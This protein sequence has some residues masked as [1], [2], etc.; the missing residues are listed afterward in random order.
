LNEKQYKPIAVITSLIFLFHP[1][2]TEVVANIKGR[3]ELLALLFALVSFYFGLLY[4]E[5]LKK[6]YLIWVIISMFLALMSKENAIAFVAIIPVAGWFFYKPQKTALFISTL[7]LILPAILFLIVRGTVLGPTY[8][9]LPDELMNNPFLGATPVQKIATVLYTWVVYFKLLIFPHPLTYDYYPYHIR[10]VD[11]SNS[12]VFSAIACLIALAILFIKGLKSKSVLSFCI[13]GFFA[14]FIL[15]SNLFFPVGTFMN[16]RFVF[17]PSVFWSLALVSVFYLWIDRAKNK[18]PQKVTIILGFYVLIFFPIKTIA[19][20]RVWANDFT[21]FTTDVKTS[22]N[23]AKSNCSAGGKLWEEAKQTPDKNKRDRYYAQ[24]EVYLRKA[25]TIYPQ[26]SDAWLLLGN[27]LFDYKKD[28]EGAAKCY[29]EV[30]KRQPGNDFAWRNIDIVVPKSTNYAWAK[31]FYTTILKV[32]STQ[33]GPNYRLGVIYGR[34]LGNLKMGQHYLERANH[35]EPNNIDGLKDL[36]T[37]YG[38]THQPQ[39]AVV[40]FEKA[41][42]IAPNDQQVCFNYGISLAQLGQKAKADSMFTVAKNLAKK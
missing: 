2:H 15:V 35:I 18:L 29:L 4:F 34:Y 8:S 12:W 25:V 26:Y 14:S 5:K 21:L 1:I 13:L 10:L 31:D 19:R 32:D 24:S 16:E 22:S 37:V 23:S 20:N 42:K 36:G 11:F 3:D 28:I 7:S 38:M 40:V 41:I 39:K 9:Q 6:R 30:V 17:M 27:L 33:F